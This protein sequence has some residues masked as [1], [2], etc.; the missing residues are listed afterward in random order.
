[1]KKILIIGGILV[2]TFFTGWFIKQ[3]KEAIDFDNL[4]RID[5]E[6]LF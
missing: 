5:N 3:V 1:M 4:Y 2:G 6:D